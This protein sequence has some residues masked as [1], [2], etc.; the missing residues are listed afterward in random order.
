MS[1][2]TIVIDAD[3]SGFVR[4]TKAAVGETKKGAKG[5]SQEMGKAFEGFSKTLIT[6]GAIK[7]ALVGAATAATQMAREAAKVSQ[8][9][10]GSRLNR[11]RTLARLGLGSDFNR[12]VENA[13][14]GTSTD[15][16]DAFLRALVGAGVKGPRAAQAFNLYAEG[17]FDQDEVISAAKRGRAGLSQLS[18]QRSQRA[19]ALGVEGLTELGIRDAERQAQTR[20]TD[21][22]SDTGA[23]A[24]IAAA[25]LAALRAENPAAFAVRDAAGA[26]TSVVGGDRIIEAGELAGVMAQQTQI[27][28]DIRAGV[29]RGTVN[30]QQDSDR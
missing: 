9:A 17:L 12:T 15:E 20:V 11:G 23:R 22:A 24:R 29:Q 7:A 16:R 19:Q 6:A 3:T 27:L 1:D 26:L 21:T 14:G 2:A 25:R 5:L 28:K 30:L 10:G 8:D 18:A 13:S 4:K